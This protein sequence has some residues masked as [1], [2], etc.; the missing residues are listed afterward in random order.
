VPAISVGICLAL[1]FIRYY[2]AKLNE[3]RGADNS[4][5]FAA[6]RWMWD[7]WRT[8]V[9]QA[10]RDRFGLE[11][12][13]RQEFHLGVRAK[14][15]SVRACHSGMNAQSSSPASNHRKAGFG[16]PALPELAQGCSAG[17]ASIFQELDE[18][19]TYHRH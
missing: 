18:E 10:R 11:R 13:I 1:S 17:T 14:A 7:A 5:F 4:D 16:A 8:G 6:G 12:R 19:P 9:I 3:S 2:A 15:N